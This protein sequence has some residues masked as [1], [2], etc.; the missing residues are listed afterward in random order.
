MKISIMPYKR[1]SKSARS[2]FREMKKLTSTQV[3]YAW[4][5]CKVVVNWGSSSFEPRPYQI[6]LNH[7]SRLEATINKLKFFNKCQEFGI[8]IPKFTSSFEEATE[9]HANFS[10]GTVERHLLT[11]SKGRGVEIVKKSESISAN[12][13]MWVERIRQRREFRFIVVGDEVVISMVKKRPRDITP[14]SIQNEGSGYKYFLTRENEEC[15]YPLEEGFEIAVKAVQSF[16][17]DFGGVDI[18]WDKVNQKWLVLEI[19]TAFGLGESNG[20]VV[21]KQLLILILSKLGV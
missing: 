6:I 2:V 10:N 9:N 19:N 8:P 12:A 11:S 5:K 13:K 3:K 4:G 14:P 15:L 7:P 20:E 1:S 18:I 21:S 16:G 17:L